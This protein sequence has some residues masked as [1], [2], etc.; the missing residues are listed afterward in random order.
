MDRNQ[1]YLAHGSGEIEPGEH[2]SAASA[3]PARWSGNWSAMESMAGT[4]RIPA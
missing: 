3:R 4:I 1:E 2:P